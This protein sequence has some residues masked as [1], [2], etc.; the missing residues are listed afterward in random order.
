MEPVHQ[1]AAAQQ[2]VLH[3]FFAGRALRVTVEMIL[4]LGH[5]GPIDMVAIN[6]IVY[7]GIKIL[8]VA[9]EEPVL[10]AMAA[11][12]HGDALLVQRLFQFSG[13][14]PAGAHLRRVPMADFAFVHLEPVVVLRHGDHILGP[15]L[16]KQVGPGG[17][18]KLFRL[19]QGNKILVAEFLVGAIGFDMMFKLRGALD[20]HAPGIPF[21]PVRG[22]GIHAPMDENAKLRVLIP[23]WHAEPG[24]RFPIVFKGSPGDHPVN[25]LEPRGAFRCVHVLCPPLPPP[26]RIH[27]RVSAAR[28]RFLLLY[29][30]HFFKS[31]LPGKVFFAFLFAWQRVSEKAPKKTVDKSRRLCYDTSV[32]R[33]R[34]MV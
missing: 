15:G 22:H 26:Y 30:T 19:E 24:Q 27:P 3:E 9:Q 1:L 8:A 18:V 20:I 28:F 32:V 25:F 23:L 7:V 2:P 21:V 33:Q 11:D 31:L 10:D 4:G 6:G 16:L 29:S 34:G 12:A 13:R 17:G 5:G 14:V